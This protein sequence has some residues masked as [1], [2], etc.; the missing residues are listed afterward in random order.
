M[1]TINERL[2]EVIG[3]L[4]QIKVPAKDLG[5][6]S[7][8]VTELLDL[9]ELIDGITAPGPNGI[10]LHL[11]ANMYISHQHEHDHGTIQITARRKPA[12]S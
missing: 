3:T 10:R 4:S 5:K 6:I 11:G 9:R 7:S 2:T 12:D 8:A 1:K